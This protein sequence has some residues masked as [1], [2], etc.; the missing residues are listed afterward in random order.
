MLI[1]F[2]V[3]ALAPT[4]RQDPQILLPDPPRFS[5]KRSTR[6]LVFDNFECLALP[7]RLDPAPT[8]DD[9]LQSPK[10]L[11]SEAA[12]SSLSKVIALG[13]FGPKPS[14]CDPGTRHSSGTQRG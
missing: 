7:S 3:E 1:F 8:K 14:R 10:N 2:S 12:K 5:A 13:G 6:K 9:G 4:G 11:I